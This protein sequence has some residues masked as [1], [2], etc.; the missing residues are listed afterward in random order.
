LHTVLTKLLKKIK[1]GN[2]IYAKDMDKI[3]VNLQ[4]KKLIKNMEK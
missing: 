4:R 3:K 2:K 1:Q